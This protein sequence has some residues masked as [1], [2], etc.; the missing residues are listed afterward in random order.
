ML[1][2]KVIQLFTALADTMYMYSEIHF[3]FEDSVYPHLEAPEW[4]V[5]QREIGR[6]GHTGTE[7]R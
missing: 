6:A 5:G 2:V 1:V 3:Q 4:S 7:A